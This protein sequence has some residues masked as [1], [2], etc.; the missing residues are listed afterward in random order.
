[1]GVHE[2]RGRRVEA[3]INGLRYSLLHYP[4]AGSPLVAIPGITTTA[5]GFDFIADAL[6]ADYEVVVPDLRGRGHSDRATAGHYGLDDYAADV[7]AIIAEFGFQDPLV[8]GHSLGARIAARWGA[9]RESHG[10]LVLV[11]PPLSG[12]HRPYPT[13]WSSFA[14]QLAEAKAGTT[15]DQVRGYYPRWPTRE[16]ELRIA[17]LPSCDDQAV[18]ETYAGF[19]T[20]EFEDDWI[21]LTPPCALI[22][23]G[24]SPMVSDADEHRLRDLA[25]T[26]PIVTVPEAGH[27]VPWDNYDGFFS[28]F[29]QIVGWLAEG[30]SQ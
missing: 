28:A 6:S 20:D 1:M 7:D 2:P 13:P 12:P 10:P 3:K 30:G 9:G 26:L 23:G 14:A 19:E 22:C 11:D 24:D 29:R 25:P 21:R 5:V 8:L 18:R 16:L 4:G 27:M 15:V 17:E